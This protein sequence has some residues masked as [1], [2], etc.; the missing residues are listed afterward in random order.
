VTGEQERVT[1]YTRAL[2]DDH[3][4][5]LACVTPFRAAVIVE[6]TCARMIQSLRVNDAATHRH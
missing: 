4:V 3:V 1:V 5:Y 6:R 2:P